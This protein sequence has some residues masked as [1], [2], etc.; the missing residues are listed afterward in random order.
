MVDVDEHRLDT[1]RRLNPPQRGGE[2][3]RIAAT[4]ESD[5]DPIIGREARVA[6][7]GQ[8]AL[9]EPVRRLPARSDARISGGAALPDRLPRV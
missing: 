9:L 8:Q 7:A 3:Q 1:E 6:R 2:R 4:G 5:D